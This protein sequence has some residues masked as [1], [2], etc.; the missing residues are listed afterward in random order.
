MLGSIPK[1]PPVTPGEIIAHIEQLKNGKAPGL[2]GIPT[3]HLKE[4]KIWWG[5]FLAPLFTHINDTDHI[6]ISCKTAI[7]VPLYK[8]G[9]GEDPANYRPISLL[10]I[11]SKLYARHLLEKLLEWLEV[12]NIIGAEQAGFQPGRSTIE[13]CLII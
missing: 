2:D 6:P 7:V 11:I 3:E 13:Q 10:N 4:N 5:S 12:E 1:W 8:K 9:K